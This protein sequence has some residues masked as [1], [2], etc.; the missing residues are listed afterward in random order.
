MS[1]NDDTVLVAGG[2][3]HFG[4][5]V[6]MALLDKGYNVHLL[7]RPPATSDLDEFVQ[8]GASVFEGNLLQPDTLDDAVR[9]AAAVVSIVQGGP[10]V[11]IDG[12]QN[13]LKA[14]E[15]HDVR[16]FIPSDYSLDYFALDYG[17]NFFSDFRKSF[18]ETMLASVVPHTFV[19]VGGF[20]DTLFDIPSGIYDFDNGIVNFWG[21]GDEPFDVTT[22]DDS[23]RFLA[24][25]VLDPIGENQTME[26]VGEI[27]SINSI[28]DTFEQVTGRTLERR[29]LGT[30]D[31]LRGW[32]ETT[33]LTA[34]SPREYAFA[35]YTWA[36][37]SGKGK[38]KNLANARYPH[39][40]PT[41]VRDYF[42]H[43]FASD[44][45]T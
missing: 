34:K 7:V 6:V 1:P 13:L 19:L 44:S 8:R 30:V 2:R 26:F 39:L 40:Q 42:E 27:T 17:D 20:I 37:L 16:R 18:A 45:V 43:R 25:V 21:S 33:K 36:Q 12:Q 24:E 41:G 35:Q 15:H 14:A 3:G 38:L 28:A 10:E 32:I 22:M 4:K 23:A 31:D 11:I 9:G 29:L 5:K